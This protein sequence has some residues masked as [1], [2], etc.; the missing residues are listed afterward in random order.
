MV[1]LVLESVHVHN[2]VRFWHVLHKAFAGWFHQWGI[3]WQDFV[4]TYLARMICFGSLKV[5]VF[6]FVFICAFVGE[7]PVNIANLHCAVVEGPRPRIS[8][9][10]ALR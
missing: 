1:L 5:R 9:S 8:L 3:S 2:G 10:R 7:A 6:V 4:L